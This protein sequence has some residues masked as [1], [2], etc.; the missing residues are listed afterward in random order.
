MPFSALPVTFPSTTSVNKPRNYHLK[1]DTRYWLSIKLSGRKADLHTPQEVGGR[2]VAS[3][4]CVSIQYPYAS[5]FEMI[6]IGHDPL[7]DQQLIGIEISDKPRIITGSG[8][9]L[10]FTFCQQ[11]NDTAPSCCQDLGAVYI[12]NA[13]C[14][15][16]FGVAVNTCCCC[17]AEEF[18]PVPTG[19]TN[20]IL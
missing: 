18:S 5:L 16:V 8:P 11:Q 9:E 1:P 15:R 19:C 14:S 20:F 17:S 12:S 6:G 3:G 13:L 4:K 10:M 7:L 2:G